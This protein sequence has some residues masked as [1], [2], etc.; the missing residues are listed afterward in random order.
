[1]KRLSQRTLQS[2]TIGLIILGVLALSLSGLLNQIVGT[3]IDPMVAVQGWFA[4]RTQ[5]IVE[6][7]TMP[8]DVATLRQE[9]ILLQDQVSQLQS[10]LLAARQQLTETDILYALL[11]YARAKPENKYIAASVIGRDPSPFMKYIIINHGSDDGIVKGMPVVTQQ[12]L[13]GKVVA[14]TATAA[15]VQLITD[16]GSVIN[17]RLEQASTD[18]QVLGSVT[19]DISLDMINP[20]VSLIQGDLILTS[21][22]GGAYPADI[23]IGQ[24]LALE[25]PDNA[26]FQK[27]SVQPVVDFVNLRAVL[28]ITNF[29]PVDYSPLVP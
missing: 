14:V 13:V 9:N 4:S 11:D 23:L 16:P 20:G 28:I 17:V 2:I 18:G 29:R 1:M 22:L 27:A 15:R 6:F 21:G 10:E 3:V 19:G 5:A 24:V 26:L 7:F 12:G 25:S 8:R